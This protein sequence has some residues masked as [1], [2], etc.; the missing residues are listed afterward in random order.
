M[1][2]R[3]RFSLFSERVRPAGAYYATRC[4]PP[5]RQQFVERAATIAPDDSL[6][7]AENAPWALQPIYVRVIV[8]DVVEL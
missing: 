3:C 7:A 2:E 8:V 1:A 6:H 4:E 5:Q